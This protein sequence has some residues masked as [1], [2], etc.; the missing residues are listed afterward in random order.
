MGSL[1]R[2]VSLWNSF[3]SIIIFNVRFFFSVE[4]VR[5]G[6]TKTT[7]ETITVSTPALAKQ[8]KIKA[9]ANTAVSTVTK[10]VQRPAAT[11]D[12]VLHASTSKAAS[13]A[14]QESVSNE[15]TAEAEEEHNPWLS[16]KTD[17]GM[18]S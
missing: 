7:T 16:A 13:H 3:Y 4:H 15:K 1:T 8:E 12:K 2:S 10:E 6:N 9:K 14:P 11:S 17:A 18:R 5:S